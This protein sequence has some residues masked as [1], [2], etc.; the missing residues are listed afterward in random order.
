MY[1]VLVTIEYSHNRFLSR[2]HQC[3]DDANNTPLIC[4]GVGIHQTY[5]NSTTLCPMSKGVDSEI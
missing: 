3:A 1:D 5:S 4:T 2:L